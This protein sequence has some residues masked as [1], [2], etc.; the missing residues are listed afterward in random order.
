MTQ[1]AALSSTPAEIN[2]FTAVLKGTI[3]SLSQLCITMCWTP[4]SGWTCLKPP[5]DPT[6]LYHLTVM[7][8]S[9]L[10]I[11]IYPSQSLRTAF[12]SS[13]N[14]LSSPWRQNKRHPQMFVDSS[15]QLHEDMGEKSSVDV[16]NNRIG[17]KDSRQTLCVFLK[18]STSMSTGGL[19]YFSVQSKIKSKVWL[20]ISFP[21]LPPKIMNPSQWRRTYLALKQPAVQDDVVA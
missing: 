17:F 13:F 5:I 3:T 19:K 10:K 4:L 15:T 9:R 11:K 16:I 1:N 6:Y 8:L 21:F 7:T 14:M 2:H 18:P 20:R 12:S